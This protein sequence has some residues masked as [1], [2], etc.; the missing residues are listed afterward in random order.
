MAAMLRFNGVLV[1]AVAIL[2]LSAA[3]GF[4]AAVRQK[5]STNGVLRSSPFVNTQLLTRSAGVRDSVTFTS[6]VLMAATPQEEQA[7]AEF[8]M[9]TEEEAQLRKIGG[10]VLGIITTVAFFTQGHNYVNL[11]TGAFAALSTYRTGAE[12]Q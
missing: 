11:S 3:Y 4:Q 6:T 2:Q 8:K 7:V 5:T 1:L 10:I 9:I 12:Y